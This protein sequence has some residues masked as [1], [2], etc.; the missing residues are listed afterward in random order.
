MKSENIPETFANRY[1]IIEKLGA[2]GMGIVYLAHDP[3]LGIDVAIKVLAKDPTGLTAAR[4][5]RE[6]TAAGKLN[7]PNIAK[8]FDFGQTDN[9]SPY[10]VMEYI[11]GKSLSELIAERGFLPISE[12]IDIF[13]QILHGLAVAHSHKII[14]RDLKPS[15]IMVT[16]SEN[17][18]NQ[19]KLLD[20]GVA[21]LE[22]YSQE[23]TSTGVLLGSPTYMSPEQSEGLDADVRSDIYSLGCLMFETLTGKPPFSGNTAFETISMHKSKAPPLLS[24]LAPEIEFSRNFILLID[25]CLSKSPGARPQNCAELLAKL[26][27]KPEPKIQVEEKV[28]DIEVQKLEPKTIMGQSPAVVAMIAMFAVALLAFGYVMI[29]ASMKTATNKKESEAIANADQDESKTNNTGLMRGTHGNAFM[30]GITSRRNTLKDGTATIKFNAA[31]E[32][33]DFDGFDKSQKSVDFSN[34]NLTREQVEKLDTMPLETLRLRGQEIND[35]T[36]RHISKIK[37]LKTFYCKNSLLTNKSLAEIGKLTNLETLR[38]G[39]PL[40]T[41]DGLSGFK[42]LKKLSSLQLD[43][44]RLGDDVAEHLSVL[45]SLISLGIGSS[46]FTDQGV[47]NLKKLPRLQTLT[48]SSQ[49]VTDLSLAHLKELKSLY[50]AN[51]GACKFSPDCCVKLEP[52]KKLYGFSINGQ[53]YFSLASAKALSKTNFSIVNLLNTRIADDHLIEI[54]KIKRLTSLSIDPTLITIRGLSALKSPPLEVLS[55]RNYLNIN[56]AIAKKFS[57]MKELR[58]LEIAHTN[59]TDN[60]LM[61]L[62]SLGQLQYLNLDGCP[63]ITS[64]GIEAFQK[65]YTSMHHKE[66]PIHRATVLARDIQEL[67]N[68]KSGKKDWRVKYKGEEIQ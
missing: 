3:V 39:C 18:H 42:N 7:H 53:R 25:S 12:A 34:I 48:I 29:S 44:D 35:D 4:L 62:A 65:L 46:S 43:G 21:K 64:E 55:F 27:D 17:G 45:P 59:I 68:F 1:K 40:V 26:Q 11:P 2:G 23:L 31:L 54:A 47:L 10:M 63:G 67:E 28:Q 9:D 19:V 38:L 5:Q 32:D 13:E 22:M 49:R 57:Q 15:N 36:I 20:F 6:A 50:T 33:S 58:S 16:P 60:Q 37:T 8:V 61:M 24:D 66:C 52:G 51:F 30:S 41:A 14:H 56:D